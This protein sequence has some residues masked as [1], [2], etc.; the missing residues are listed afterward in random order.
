MAS[1][2]SILRFAIQQVSDTEKKW[3]HFCQGIRMIKNSWI[4]F[5]IHMCVC[6]HMYIYRYEPVPGDSSISLQ[7][8]LWWWEYEQMH[9]NV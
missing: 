8:N 5:A 1:A 3:A 6:V 9:E 4:Y 2:H 7:R